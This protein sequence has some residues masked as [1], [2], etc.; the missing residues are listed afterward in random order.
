MLY[1]NNK[2]IQK[3]RFAAEPE[4]PQPESAQPTETTPAVTPK[5][6]KSKKNRALTTVPMDKQFVWN[7][8]DQNWNVEGVQPGAASH[9]NPPQRT[10]Y[11]YFN[12]GLSSQSNNMFLDSLNGSLVGFRVLGATYEQTI[13]PQMQ[14]EYLTQFVAEKDVYADWIDN[15][16][17]LFLSTTAYG[18]KFG[19]QIESLTI[20]LLNPTFDITVSKPV[21][22]GRGVFSYI[23]GAL[24]FDVKLTNLNAQEQPSTEENTEEG[25][26]QPP[27]AHIERQQQM[28]E[29]GGYPESPFAGI[30][31][32]RES[33]MQINS[34][35]IKISG[36][37]YKQIEGIV[38][39]IASANNIN[40]VESIKISLNENS[41]VV[42]FKIA[43]EV[44]YPELVQQRKQE[45]AELQ[46]EQKD[47]AKE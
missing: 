38:S 32:R 13:S 44:T 17:K 3:S 4:V 46:Q 6:T 23:L 34:S 41:G 8:E 27:F 7:P 35:T 30:E 21:Q 42:S 16:I 36:E 12:Y 33:T 47:F 5:K 20:D 1:S 18:Q 25:Y 22:E 10:S 26:E 24:S 31:G 9:L 2:Y 29:E 43:E 45:N 40:N 19:D 39:K 11:Q 14:K 37:V 28:E 15:D